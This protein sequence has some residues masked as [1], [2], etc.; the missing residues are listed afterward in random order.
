MNQ[1]ISCP[2]CKHN[3]DITNSLKEQVKNEALAE[4]RKEYSQYMQDIKT[5]KENFQ[6]KANQELA[7]QI[8]LEK[9]KVQDENLSQFT[10]LQNELNQKSEQLQQFNKAKAEIE[11]LKREKTEVK[12]QVEM[13]F[14]EK[15]N[16]EIITEKEKM[17]SK[18]Q[19]ENQQQFEELQN[20]LNQKS[21]QL[22]QFNKAK[23]EIEKLKREKSEVASKIEAELQEK[24]TQQLLD[25]KE[26]IR[27]ENENHNNMKLLEKDTMI[28]QQRKDLAKMK[29]RLEQG[30]TQL[31]GEVQELAIER[32]LKSQFP[33]DEIIEVKKGQYGSDVI[34]VIHERERQNCGTIAYE[35]KRTANWGNDW[36]EKFK[37]DMQ[38]AGSTI[39]ILVTSVMPSNMERAGIK[40]G[41]WV[42][43]FDEFKIISKLLR[44]SV[45]KIDEVMGH[46][47][48][49]KEKMEL[50]Y[51]YMF[52]SEFK[53][54]LNNMLA[55]FESM[56]RDL[57]KEKT[58]MLS[59]WKK[60]EKHLDLIIQATSS[61]SGSITGISG[62]SLPILE[63]SDSTFVLE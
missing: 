21:E 59:H 44:D 37:S 46:K 40:D 52:G 16:Q 58:Q 5:E 33:F 19:N 18:I 27:V 12:S 56:Q 28:E 41:V 3:F 24:L 42:C 9:A 51:D 32:W 17:K 50:L 49:R 25:E 61:I 55:I 53:N 47:N 2:K 23:A 43:R 31:Q 15:L 63:E 60:R 57:T 26:K 1:D 36:I 34:Q 45:I 35:S 8:Q 13:E 54:D 22:Q 38:K 48:N 62:I 29:T 11:K 39:G 20:E 4:A 30:S 14:Q 10:E 6:I 7:K